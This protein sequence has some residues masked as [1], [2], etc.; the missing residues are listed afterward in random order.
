[1]AGFVLSGVGERVGVAVR[2]AS[3]VVGRVLN[4]LPLEKPLRDFAAGIFAEV[5]LLNSVERALQPRIGNDTMF[6]VMPVGWCGRGIVQLPV[7]VRHGNLPL[8]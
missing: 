1:M 4:A 5:H 7:V 6:V 3:F 2:F 8:K